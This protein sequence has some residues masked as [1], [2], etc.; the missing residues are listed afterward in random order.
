[1]ATVLNRP[2]RQVNL[3][4]S[5]ATYERLLAEHEGNSGVRFTYNQGELEILVPSVEHEMLTSNVETLVETL[6]DEM[7]IDFQRTRSTTFQ[8]QDLER[9]FEPDSSFYFRNAEYVR[10]KEWL[11]LTKDPAPELVIEIDVTSES[12]NKFPIHAAFGVPEIWR[13]SNRAMSILTLK[14]NK[15][16]EQLQSSIFPK[17]TASDLTDLIRSSQ[18]LRRPIWIKHIRGWAHGGVSQR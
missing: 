12:M 8:R 14:R 2:E 1:M 11:N 16:T 10:G 9:G 7:N 6:A 3:T 13:Y 17:V 4:V 5:W 18:E 15:Y